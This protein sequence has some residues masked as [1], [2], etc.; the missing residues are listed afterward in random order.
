[1]YT[2]PE[3]SQYLNN[4]VMPEFIKYINSKS[5]MMTLDD[6]R[7]HGQHFLKDYVDPSR[8]DSRGDIY[9]TFEKIK[10]YAE[11]HKMINQGRET[12]QSSNMSI[13]ANGIIWAL[14]HDAFDCIK[15]EP[16]SEWGMDIKGT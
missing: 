12:V 7:Y 3:V 10:D 5:E 13:L 11:V 4:E 8:V 14:E 2:R 6:A 16:F 1:M 9:E 15:W